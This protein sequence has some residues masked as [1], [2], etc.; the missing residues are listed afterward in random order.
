MGGRAICPDPGGWLL[1]K[2][3]EDEKRCDRG[4]FSRE[5]EVERP[6]GRVLRGKFD[7]I[8]LKIVFCCEDAPLGESAQGGCPVDE[9]VALDS[10]GLQHGEV[11][12]AERG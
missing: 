1:A 9:L 5:D 3:P 12:V 11:E 10:H 8:P 4:P 7:E 2:S 6:Y